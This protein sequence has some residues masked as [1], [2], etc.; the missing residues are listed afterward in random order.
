MKTI[1][2][3]VLTL[4]TFMSISCGETEETPQNNRV[5]HDSAVDMQSKEEPNVGADSSTEALPVPPDS[6]SESDQEETD[7][8]ETVDQ[9]KVGSL[10]LGMNNREVVEAIGDPSEKTP[11]VHWAATGESHQDWKY[12]N[13]GIELDMI[14]AAGGSTVLGGITLLENATLKTAR[15]VGVGSTREEVLTAY[16]DDIAPENDALDQDQ[17]IVGSIYG[18]IF[19]TLKD[20]VVT[21]VFVGAGAE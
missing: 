1:T 15:N 11:F 13:K 16:V 17:V 4:F 21:K 8:A 7:E 12:P 10:Y 19:F 14:E 18:G 3:S 2:L 20:K 5:T 6:T 9:E